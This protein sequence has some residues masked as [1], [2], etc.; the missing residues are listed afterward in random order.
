MIE[1]LQNRIKLLEEQ[2]SET[3]SPCPFS[4]ISSSG[5]GEET[6]GRTDKDPYTELE[7]A[8]E[9]LLE[10]IDQL[11]VENTQLKEDMVSLTRG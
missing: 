3:S 5:G 2:L 8:N 1:S 7:K 9:K 6:G 11:Q 4:P 10:K